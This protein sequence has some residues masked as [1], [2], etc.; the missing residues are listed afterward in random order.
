MKEQL[1]DEI[2]ETFKEELPKHKKSCFRVKALDTIL[3]LNLSYSGITTEYITKYILKDKYELDDVWLAMFT[4]LE[5]E[6][7]I[8]LVYCKTANDIVWN[9]IESKND[10]F[11]IENDELYEEGILV[12][13]FD[14]RDEDENLNKLLLKFE[15]YKKYEKSISSM[16]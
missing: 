10:W 14:F 5:Y 13:S 6:E 1:I 15:K 7:D 3:D 8:A 16:V 12:K 11:I 2:V 4:I 9:F